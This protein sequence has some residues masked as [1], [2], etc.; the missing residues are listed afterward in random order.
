MNPFGAI[1]AKNARNL[2][3]TSGDEPTA[4]GEDLKSVEIYP[5]QVGMN[6]RSSRSTRAMMYL[7]HASGDEPGASPLLVGARCST[8]LPHTSGD[9]PRLS[10]DSRESVLTI[11][12]ASGD[13]PKRDGRHADTAMSTSTL[14]K[15]G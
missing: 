5:T 13:E 3:H 14:R 1:L 8:T 12:Y 6:P 4:L 9:E 11:P 10:T 7:P 15:W 2:P